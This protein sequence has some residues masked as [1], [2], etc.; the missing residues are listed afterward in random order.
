MRTVT[1]YSPFRSGHKSSYITSVSGQQLCMDS[2]TGAV[3]TVMWELTYK[4]IW[5]AEK[6]PPVQL[7]KHIYTGDTIPV[8]GVVNVTVN[9]KQQTKQHS[10]LW[11]LNY[12]IVGMFGRRK[13]WR[14]WQI[15]S[16]SPN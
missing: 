15:I 10:T 8:L 14:I 9:H 1:Q 2:G 12:H 4:T 5:N 7:T 11:R 6:V 3:V 16:D 13:V